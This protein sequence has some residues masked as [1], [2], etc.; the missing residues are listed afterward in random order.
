[1]KSN[2]CSFEKLN[3]Q[4]MKRIII[5]CS[6]CL[7]L[8][9]CLATASAQSTAPKPSAAKP[10]AAQTP[11]AVTQPAQYVYHKVQKGETVYSIAKQY[12][13][14][15]ETIFRLNPGCRDQL[16]AGATLR[17]PNPETPVN[18]EDIAADTLHIREKLLEFINDAREI[19][20]MSAE[21]MQDIK[22]VERQLNML[23]TKWNTYYTAKQANI[24]DN[25]AL[26]DL[27]TQY[28]QLCQDTQDSLTTLKGGLEMRNN[29]NKADK[30]IETQLVVYQDFSKRAAEYS[31][32]SAF[33]SKLEDLKAKEQIVFADIEKNYQ[34]AQAAAAQ[35]PAYAKRMAQIT[36]HYV[37]LK[38]LSDKVRAAEYKPFFTRIKNYLF[39]LA[40]VAVVLMFANM[41]QTKYKTYKEL[42]KQ[43]K[44]MEKMR[45]E[46]DNEYPTI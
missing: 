6:F 30:F 22:D 39:G 41:M 2:Y 31:L 10:S 33:A 34:L 3:R 25:E 18:P 24:G 1:M 21:S 42:K 46:T 28:Q 12:K 13:A 35:N 7:L 26:T 20:T 32:A 5:Y 11:V 38:K 23:N 9:C 43:A 36:S 45:R 15:V 4:Y 29:F 27:V 37:E 44:V 16:W 40:A 8:A 14:D 19:S 17:I